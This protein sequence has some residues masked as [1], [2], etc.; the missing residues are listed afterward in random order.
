MSWTKMQL[1][2]YLN[3]AE[4]LL[5]LLYRKCEGHK[6]MAR[7]LH[8]SVILKNRVITDLSERICEHLQNNS[9]LRKQNEEMWQRNTELVEENRKLKTDLRDRWE[10]ILSLIGDLAAANR[11]IEALKDDI[12]LVKTTLAHRRPWHFGRPE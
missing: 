2:K 10:K 5:K 4:E 7:T 12:K 6:A 3:Q 8:E 9:V 1:G 11:K